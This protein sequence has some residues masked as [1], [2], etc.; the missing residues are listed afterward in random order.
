MKTRIASFVTAVVTLIIAGFLYWLLRDMTISQD[1]WQALALVVVW[2]I[3]LILYL[4]SFGVLFT[5]IIN[6]IKGISSCYVAIKVLSIILLILGLA[7]T[8]LNVMVLKTIF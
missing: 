5:S 8:G 7:L 2:P 6:S 1:G 4:L 3:Y